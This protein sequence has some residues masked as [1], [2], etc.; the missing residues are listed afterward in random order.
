M[1]PD[2]KDKAWLP[3]VGDLFGM[4]DKKANDLQLACGLMKWRGK[5]LAIVGDSWTTLQSEYGVGMG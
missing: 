5:T 3:S 1:L 4:T 2:N